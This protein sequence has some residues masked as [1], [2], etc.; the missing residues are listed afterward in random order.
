M[1][2]FLCVIFLKKSILLKIYLLKLGIV[3]CVKFQKGQNLKIVHMTFV[4]YIL[5]FYF[6][7]FYFILFKFILNGAH[8]LVI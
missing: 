7:L 1:L 2:L 5:T 8:I 6:V 3:D 4:H